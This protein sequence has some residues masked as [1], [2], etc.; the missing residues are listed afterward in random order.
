MGL[1]DL[2]SKA[3]G[4]EDTSEAA[5]Q[6]LKEILRATSFHKRDKKC[7]K[8]RQFFDICRLSKPNVHFIR[9]AY[10]SSQ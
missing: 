7:K 10:S 4:R 3:D 5:L 9:D 6:E 2:L 1:P 8:E